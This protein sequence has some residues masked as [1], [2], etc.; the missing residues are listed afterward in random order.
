MQMCPPGYHYIS[1]V[2]PA[3]GH[4][5]VRLH[6]HWLNV[7]NDVTYIV[8]AKQ[9]KRFKALKPN[10]IKQWGLHNALVL[11]SPAQSAQ[12]SRSKGALCT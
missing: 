2:I 8:S 6:V 1:I 9:F 3:L 5:N 7:N 10:C 11:G 12:P 4:R